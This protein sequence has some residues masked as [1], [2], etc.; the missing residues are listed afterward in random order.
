MSKHYY[1]VIKYTQE[2]G[3][4]IDPESES[5]KF[6]NGTIFDTQEGE[7]QH[8]YLGEGEY[9]GREEELT[10]TLQSMLFLHNSVAGEGNNEL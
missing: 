9:N 2:A 7:W 6:P 10:D 4:Q 5:E 1:Y 3:W 8:Q